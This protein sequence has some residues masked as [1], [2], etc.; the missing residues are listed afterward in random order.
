MKRKTKPRTFTTTVST[1]VAPSLFHQ[2][3]V[4]QFAPDSTPK[5]YIDGA[6]IPCPKERAKKTTRRKR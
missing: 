2:H 4:V 6:E 5:V 3:V 1:W